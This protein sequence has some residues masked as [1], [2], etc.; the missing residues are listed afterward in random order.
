MKYLL[1]LILFLNIQFLYSQEGSITLSYTG[2]INNQIVRLD[3]IDVL[4]K[5]NGTD[6]AL[7]APD[8]I[9]VINLSSSS[10]NE[11]TNSDKQ[12]NI[13]QNYPNPFNGTTNIDLYVPK[14]AYLKLTVT[15]I[16]G[17]TL[18]VYNNTFNQ[19][20]YSFI[21]K[22]SEAMM[23]ILTIEGLHKRISVKML[24]S[25]RNLNN[26][27][28]CS[29]ELTN[30]NVNINKSSNSGDTFEYKQ[31][32]QLIHTGFSKNL[33]QVISGDAI[34][35]SPLNDTS[36]I[37]NMRTGIPCPG[38]PYVDYEGKAYNTVQ[39]GQLCWFKE[40]LNVGT[41]ITTINY[42]HNN[43][44][45]EKYCYENDQ[46]NCEIYGGL[47]QWNEMMQYNPNN[48]KGICP[49][50]WHVATDLD[51]KI[52]EGTVD[53]LYS[54][55]NLEWNNMDTWR[56]FDVGRR[57]KADSGW[58]SNGNGNDNFGFAALPGG[59]ADT[60]LQF[61]DIQEEGRW[62]TSSK[63]NYGNPILRGLKY[64]SDQSLRGSSA[65]NLPCSV[66]CVKD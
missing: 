48:E 30:R 50:G 56:G 44:V 31:G 2:K 11:L 35:D 1:L 47:Y 54:L 12:F 22:S 59:K 15:D 14:R 18:A 36:Y 43:G 28:S 33:N 57:L 7:Y 8:T 16:Y 65:N 46:D 13:S 39:I 26:T 40:N 51:W 42:M 21:I 37:F 6:T 4:N 23:N 49:T 3:S 27:G 41:F 19:G 20:A 58:F 24:N 60:H 32:D 63:E 9:L 45:L 53:S 25:G 5:S 66:R 29:I 55:G 61:T 52:L 64:Y 10:V 34:I 62:W 38:I 17:R